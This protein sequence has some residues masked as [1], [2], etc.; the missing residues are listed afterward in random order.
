MDLL[1]LVMA[2]QPLNL[3]VRVLPNLLQSESFRRQR[4][5]ILELPIGASVSRLEFVRIC[6]QKGELSEEAPRFQRLRYL[7]ARA[8]FLASVESY[9]Y[10]SSFDPTKLDLWTALE[11]GIPAI[12]A[13]ALASVVTHHFTSGI[14]T[15]YNDLKSI[16]WTNRL[17]TVMQIIV[18]KRIL[19]LAP[20]ELSQKE[21]ILVGFLGL[22]PKN[23][24]DDLSVIAGKATLFSYMNP[25]I[26][27]RSPELD[28]LYQD[29]QIVPN[30]KGGIF[31]EAGYWP[32]FNVSQNEPDAT[33]RILQYGAYPLIW[34]LQVPGAEVDVTDLGVPVTRSRYNLINNILEDV[35]MSE[36]INYTVLEQY[37][38]IAGYVEVDTS[39]QETANAAYLV[40]RYSSHPASMYIFH[41]PPVSAQGLV[42]YNPALASIEAW[43]P[44]ADFH[45]LRHRI[46]YARGQGIEKTETWNP[47]TITYPMF[48]QN[49]N[50]TDDEIRHFLKK[51]SDPTVALEFENKL[52]ISASEGYEAKNLN[53]LQQ[54]S[55]WTR[56]EIGAFLLGIKETVAI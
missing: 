22:S 21:G 3:F 41:T 55:A 48:L 34:N 24:K 20:T 9:T 25:K 6:T 40:N 53:I 51:M 44:H 14:L 45:G 23:L 17:Y 36:E 5:Q 31:L 42:L 15:Q 11:S 8:L 26:N 28:A 49:P 52:A 19:N 56:W 46:A 37:R 10:F 43:D 16:P 2:R 32:P 18:Q 50:V 33:H 1:R 38:V 47:E 12:Q 4:A 54:Q 39:F 27:K 35:E 13:V 30:T 7:I 29:R